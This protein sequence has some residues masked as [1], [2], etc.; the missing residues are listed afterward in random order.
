MICGS[1]GGTG[2]A[3]GYEPRLSMGSGFITSAIGGGTTAGIAGVVVERS[4]YE[5]RGV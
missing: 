2:G 4:T 1:L 5:W 3:G